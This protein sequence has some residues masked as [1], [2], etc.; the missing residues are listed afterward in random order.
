MDTNDDPEDKWSDDNDLVR[1]FGFVDTLFL[2]E[3][4]AK[5]LA[6][7]NNLT[8]AMAKLAQLT[9]RVVVKLALAANLYR[10]THQL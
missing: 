8:D 7:T 3:R 2:N 9:K 4:E 6:R 1:T 10:S 5:K